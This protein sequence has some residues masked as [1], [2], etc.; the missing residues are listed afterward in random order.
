MQTDFRGWAPAVVTHGP[1]VSSL[2][3]NRTP[4]VAHPL[5]FRGSPRVLIHPL[6]LP[7]VHALWIRRQFLAPAPPAENTIP[8]LL[9]VLGKPAVGVCALTHLSII[10]LSL[11]LPFFTHM[12]TE[13]STNQHSPNGLRATCPKFKN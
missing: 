9:E 8:I 12:L 7:Q 10:F 6:F 3:A 2:Q 4:P 1:E 13:R 11:F 5:L